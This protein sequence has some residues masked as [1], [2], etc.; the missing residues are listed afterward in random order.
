MA[1]GDISQ[2]ALVRPDA[3]NHPTV[4]QFDLRKML[5]KGRMLEN[6]LLRP[7]DLVYVPDKQAHRPLS[8]IASLFWPLSSLLNLLR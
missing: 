1:D 6:E 7:G 3:S 2:V 5:T 4:R 8:E